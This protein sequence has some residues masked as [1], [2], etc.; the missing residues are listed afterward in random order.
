MKSKIIFLLI[1]MFLLNGL[2]N[3]RELTDLAIVSAIGID[4]DDNGKYIVTSQ[5]LNTK[6]ENSSGSGA[7]SSNSSSEIVVLSTSEESIQAALRNSIEE[8]PKRLY[9]AHMELLLISEK[10]AREEEILDILD[11]F[12]RD[13]EGSNNFMLVIAKNA[14]PEELLNIITPLESSPAQNIKDSILTTHR[15]RGIST[16]NTL[17]E[18]VAMFKKESQTSVIASIE[19]NKEN[20]NSDDNTSKKEDIQESSATSSSEKEKTSNNEDEQIKVSDLA[21]FK[22]KTLTGYLTQKESYIYNILTNDASGGIL[23]VGKDDDLLVVEQIKSN[24]KLTPRIENDEY[25]IDIS[26]NMSC[27]ITETGKN[28]TFDTQENI[29]NYQNEVANTLKNQIETLIEKSK[30]EY[31]C[32]ILSFGNVFYKYKNKDYNKMKEK[33]GTEYYKYINTTVNVKVT[34]PTEGGV[35]NIW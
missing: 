15:Y 30:N 1:V 8:S 29:E 10:I 28:V 7:G 25:F 2:K 13:N 11:F 32:D 34:F 35:D 33:Y 5:I 14:T 21:Y 24:A 31:D 6:K 4:L 23:E 20:K 22:Y 12:I 3:S 19:L 16:N 17:S 18:N 26:V 27:N 9:L